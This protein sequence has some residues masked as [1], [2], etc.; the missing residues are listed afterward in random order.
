MRSHANFYRQYVVV[1]DVRRNPRRNA[2]SA[3]A[4]MSEDVVQTEYTEDEL[5]ARFELH[6]EKMGQPGEWA[7]N[8]EVS[9]FAS[10]FDLH[11]RLWQAD[12][13]ILIS[14]S[15]DDKPREPAGVDK[16]QILHLAYHVS[17][18]MSNTHMPPSN[19]P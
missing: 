15:F 16:R 5:Q 13:S 14:P 4:S 10:A 9:A 8:M 12:T 1:K 3:T 7:D 2:R 11:V 6:L 19:C 17:I 18:T